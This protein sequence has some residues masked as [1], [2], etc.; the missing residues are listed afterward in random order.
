MRGISADKRRWNTE[1][2]LREFYHGR[3][4]LSAYPRLIQL[5]STMA[6]NLRCI[7]CMRTVE[8]VKAR[9]A[10]RRHR[11]DREMPPEVFE[12]VL[13][14]M[15]YVE[16]F[17]L[18]PFGESFL[19]SQFDRILEEHERQQCENLTMTTAGNLIDAGRA[20]RIVRAGVR[21]VKISIEETEPERYAR[22]RV[23]AKLE[24]VAE[25]IRLLNEWKERL[26]TPFPRLTLAASYMKRNIE[27]LPDMVHFAAEH[28][29][30]EIYVQML[31]LKYHDD[32]EMR[33][34]ELTFHVPL[35]QRMV[36]EAEVAAKQRGLAFIVTDP[37]RNL[38]SDDESGSAGQTDS[39]RPHRHLTQKCT[40]PWWWAYIDENGFLWPC[41]WAKVQFGSLQENSFIQVW[42]SDVAVD[43]RR[44]FLAD[45]IP[46]Y[47]R[48][49]LC[50]V[51]FD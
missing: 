12:Q 18:T 29:V 14:L 10:Q 41:C 40:N 13:A 19:F 47:C 6:C 2:S 1:L 23:G 43:M 49:Q 11:L 15:P 9:H 7:F 33:A 34:E 30:P 28:G 36:G 39:P 24:Q 38:L 42:N 21:Q 48:G 31:E 50:H 37:I 46:N 25:G 8:L 51:D 16:S 17:D 4:R 20:E 26:E 3:L 35:L 44:R 32:P 27:R 5:G 45:D 22:M